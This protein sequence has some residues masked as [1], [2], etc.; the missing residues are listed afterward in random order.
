MANEII[1]VRN[2]QVWF[3]V[4][5]GFV[6]S[7]VSEEQKYVKAVDGITFDI[8]AREIF[9]LV[10]E[11]GCGKTTTGKAILRLVEPTGGEV[12]YFGPGKD[13]LLRQM[14]PTSSGPRHK[15]AVYVADPD[16]FEEYLE[17]DNIVD[18]KRAEGSIGATKLKEL[19]KRSKLEPKGEE[20]SLAEIRNK[21]DRDRLKP[22]STPVKTNWIIPE[23][24][25]DEEIVDLRRARTVL[26]EDK[27]QELLE[28]SNL[29]PEDDE[30]K[31]SGVEDPADKKTL[32]PFVTS[33]RQMVLENAIKVRRRGALSKVYVSNKSRYDDLVEVDQIVNL[34]R[35][36]DSFGAARLEELLKRSKLRLEGDEINLEM[37]KNDADRKTLKRF[38]R[39]LVDLKRAQTSLGA[40]R[41]KELLEQSELKP[42]GDTINLAKVKGSADKK[43]LAPFATQLVDL[44]SAQDGLGTARLKELLKRSKLRL[45]GDEVNLLLI[46]N[47]ADKKTLKPFSSPVKTNWIVLSKVP[48]SMRAEVI[49]DAGISVRTLSKHSMKAMRQKL[50]IIFQDPYESLNPKQSIYDIIAEPLVVNSIGANEAEREA[51]VTKALDDAGLR[52]PKNFMWRYPHEVSGGQRQRVGVAGA[53]V[54]DPDFLVADE[55]VSML[56]VSIRSEILKLMLDLREQK[57][58]SFLFITHDLGVAYV[59][60]DRIG[61][62]YLG[63]IVELGPTE[64]VIKNPQHPYTKA[65]ISVV[66]TPDPK[67]RTDKIILR[68]ERPDPSN[69]PPGCRFHPRCPFVMDICRKVAPDPLFVSEGH[70]VSCH[71]QRQGPSKASEGAGER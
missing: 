46:R 56:D 1:S 27:F 54:L 44:G 3:P 9:C 30:V 41:L 42:E 57:G 14:I 12:A 49:R 45:E 43:T 60:S 59:F 47:D 24:V 34:T 69:I 51:R 5:R 22:F 17:I 50:Q 37:I 25:P 15:K 20:I 32:K 7:L 29:K 39:R 68:G 53:L 48:M 65:L 31:L 64:K 33:R 21:A 66:P 28:R 8:K 23:K 18:L 35:A 36:R 19:L 6:E 58:L 16:K 4:R 63:K 70:W 11:S 10:G 62:M 26:A 67:D 55:P 40:A 2:L 71:L 13:E 61:I 38:A 52:P